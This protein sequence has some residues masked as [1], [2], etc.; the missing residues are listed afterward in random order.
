MNIFIQHIFKLVCQWLI[1]FVGFVLSCMHLSS[2]P[3][4]SIC[5]LRGL[6]FNLTESLQVEVVC[7]YTSYRPVGLP[8]FFADGNG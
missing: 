4:S 3:E 6:E 1:A 2:I 5:P 8:S 7:V